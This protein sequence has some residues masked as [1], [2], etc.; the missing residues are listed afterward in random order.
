MTG[1]AVIGL[2]YWGPKIARNLSRLQELGE[3]ERLIACDL[4]EG[5]C[6]AIKSQHPKAETTT[7]F[8]SVLSN[9]SIKG[10]VIATP[11]TTH[12]KIAKQ[13]L[14]AGKHIMIEKPLTQT[15][16]QAEELIKIA[17]EKKLVLMAGHTFEYTSAVNKAKEIIDS[18]ELGKILFVNSSRLNLGLFQLDPIDV[19][20]DLAPHDISIINFWLGKEPKAVSASGK[21][22]FIPG[23]VDDAHLCMEYS[24]GVIANVHDSWLYPVKDR[25]MAVV[26]TKKMLVYDIT[27]ENE[28]TV[29]DKGVDLLQ[30]NAKSAKDISYRDKGAV[31]IP[32]EKTEALQA[33]LAHFIECIEQGKAPKTS[34]EIGLRVVKVLEAAEHS[35][36]HNGA[37]VE[38][39]E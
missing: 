25:E 14:L 5:K 3:V 38:I 18:G 37:R 9:K 24:D 29:Y 36:A 16:K 13:A 39:R 32:T 28:L 26:G 30:E 21:S 11:V 31:P 1:I 2:G 6:D 23:I 4:N 7:D 19:L 8:D 17:R 22:H 20:Y 27:K 34:G 10:L 12:Y 35:L 33:E 15:A